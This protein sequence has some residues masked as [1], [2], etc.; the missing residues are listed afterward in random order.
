MPHQVLYPSHLL[1]QVYLKKEFLFW[2]SFSTFNK[3]FTECPD[4]FLCKMVPPHSSQI[5]VYAFSAF[6][7]KLIQDICPFC[8]LFV[9][10]SS[11]SLLIWNFLIC[12]LGVRVPV[13]DKWIFLR[14]SLIIFNKI[15]PWVL[16]YFSEFA[17]MCFRSIQFSYPHLK[18]YCTSGPYFWRLFAFSQQIKQLWTKNLWIWSEMFQETQKSQFY[19]SRGN[20]CKVTVKNMRKS[21]FYMFWTINQ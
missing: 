14:S 11:T 13:H 20:C 17:L 6:L 1:I 19:F 10:I 21:I 18:G 12:H 5:F 15:Q 8:I 3:N 16:N 4:L 2:C 9:Y 7:E